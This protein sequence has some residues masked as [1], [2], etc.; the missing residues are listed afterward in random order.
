MLTE[1]AVRIRCEQGSG[2]TF[3]GAPVTEMLLRSDMAGDPTELHLGSVLFF[4]IERM[5]K[6]AIRVKDA[7][8]PLFD[9]FGGLEY[10][11][12]DHR[13]LVAARFEPY[14]NAKRLEFVDSVG[15]ETVEEVPGALVFERDGATYRIDVRREG[16]EFFVVFGDE[17][18]GAGSN[19]GETYGGGRYIYTPLPDE[20]GFVP[21]DFN[22][23]YNPPCV[24]TPYATCP[25]PTPENRLPICYP[26]RREALQGRVLSSR[27]NGFGW[28]DEGQG[29]P[30]LLL[31][32]SAATKW[33]WN[34][35]RSP[36]AGRYRT[37]ALDFWGYG[38]TP[39]PPNPKSFDLDREVELAERL[40]ERVDTPVDLVGHSYGGAVAMELAL[41]Q[42]SIVRN[43][44][45]H[46]PVLFHLLKGS[47]F[48]YEWNEIQE[49]TSL[50][51]AEIEAG[52][53]EAAAALFVDYW[54]GDGAWRMIPRD[55]QVRA[56][57][58]AAKAPLDFRALFTLETPLE[59]YAELR[60]R[61]L[62]TVGETTRAPARR[63]AEL[64]ARAWGPGSMQ[65]VEGAGHMAP[66]T[67]PDRLR[68]LIEPMLA[69]PEG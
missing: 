63:V 19:G 62:V 11:P 4:V 13:W 18:N 47:E 31:H 5:G 25:R 20:N 45:V 7:E 51:S 55:K 38:E 16:D 24:F 61:A 29:P 69:N 57:S 27:A 17:T 48:E 8:N 56:A 26:S 2:V 30:I 59:R 9:S 43:I 53:P 41:K 10:Y 3:D 14:E 12:V 46:E 39:L 44:I 66:I 68:P 28:L 54:N 65:V 36:W 40:L 34:R 60:D 37:L 32:S 35:L 64:L 33:Q 21:L 49:I 58:M 23:A 42:P 22:R 15:I 6:L 52:R 67:A 1:G 50:T